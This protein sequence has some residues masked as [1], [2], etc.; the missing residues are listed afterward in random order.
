MAEALVAEG[1][2]VF[3]ID[4]LSTGS[5][6]NL[7]GVR[8]HPKFHFT[9]ASVLDGP[10]LEEV[11]GRVDF[12]YHLAA[13]VGVELVVKSP[14]FTIEDNVRGT[15]NALAAAAKHSV[16]I[17]ITSTSEV[18]GKSDRERFREDESYVLPD[19]SSSCKRT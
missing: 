1:K 16:G 11:A 2:E 7:A 13:A 8:G 15:E 12:I 3:A 18:Y 5:L 9:Q 6:A 10:A 17:L 14:V 4:D 19:A